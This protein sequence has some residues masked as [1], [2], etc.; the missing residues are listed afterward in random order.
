MDKEVTAKLAKVEAAYAAMKRI[1][2]A[3]QEQRQAEIG[4]WV[5]IYEAMKAPE[6]AAVFTALDK[7]L[8]LQ[9]LVK[10]DPKKSS[11]ILGEMVK[12]TGA[13]AKQSRKKAQELAN[14]LAELQP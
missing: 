5:K 4:K 14:M 3:A 7:D 1:S 12:G 13:D 9:I 6:A 10:M 8:A 11:K 2:D